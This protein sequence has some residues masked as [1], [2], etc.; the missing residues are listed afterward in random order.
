[1]K[2]ESRNGSK[3]RDQNLSSDRAYAVGMRLYTHIISQ[4]LNLN[5]NCSPS[6]LFN[7]RKLYTLNLL[8][9]ASSLLL[10]RKKAHNWG[11]RA[12]IN[13]II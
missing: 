3:V 4:T 9:I 8:P 6:G 10:K 1:M 13:T 2:D 7:R 5:H 11:F 12:S